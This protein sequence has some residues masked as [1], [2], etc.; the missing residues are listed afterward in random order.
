MMPEPEN[1]SDFMAFTPDPPKRWHWSVIAAKLAFMLVKERTP[2]LSQEEA[3]AEA[4]VLLS[5]CI[6]IEGG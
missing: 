1:G 3:E 6:K 4:R 5:E 2:E